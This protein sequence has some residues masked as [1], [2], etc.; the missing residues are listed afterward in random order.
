MFK[1]LYKLTMNV[2]NDFL[3][4]WCCGLLLSNLKLFSLFSQSIQ[5]H[6][7][8]SS[9]SCS[10]FKRLIII[11]IRV[12]TTVR[13]GGEYAWVVLGKCAVSLLILQNEDWRLANNLPWSSW[14]NL[15]CI[16][17]SRLTMK[18]YLKNTQKTIAQLVVCILVCRMH[19]F[20]PQNH[21]TWAWWC[22]PLIPSIHGQQ[23]KA[24]LDYMLNLKLAFL[25]IILHG[26]EQFGKFF[27]TE[28]VE[29]GQEMRR[30]E[31]LQPHMGLLDSFLQCVSCVSP[32]TYQT[33]PLQHFIRIHGNAPRPV[34]VARSG[35]SVWSGDTEGFAFLSLCPLSLSSFFFPWHRLAM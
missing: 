4:V 25:H 29:T 3:F 30:T 31:Y 22:Q 9:S 20:S 34:W 10:H 2:T 15:D 1:N 11:T 19:W 21:I 35:G 24:I 18:S 32:N 12:S 28:A 23:F 14:S 27:M 8:K 7:N 16:V 17:S 5:L 6:R 13:M 26:H 33:K